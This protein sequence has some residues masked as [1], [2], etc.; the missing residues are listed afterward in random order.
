MNDE[1]SAFLASKAPRPVAVGTEPLPMHKA[2]FDYQKAATAFCIRQGRA[3]LFLDT[4]LGKA[5]AS[6]T[7]VVTPAGYVPIGKLLPGDHVIGADGKPTKVLGVFPQGERPGFRVTFSDDSSL[8][9]DIEHLWNVRTKTQRHRGD[10]WKTWTLAQ[11]MDRGLRADSGTAQDRL[12]IPMVDPVQFNETTDELP[13]DP[14]VLGC[15]IG[16]GGL[17]SYT[18]MMTSAD[19]E[20]IDRI[21]SALP[22]GTSIER[23]RYTKY[24]WVIAGTRGG[25]HHEANRVTDAL[26]DLGLM[27]HGSPEKFVP[28]PYLLG[29]EDTRRALLQGLLDTDG[30]VWLDNGCPVIEFCT[31]SKKLADD[32]VFLVQSLGGKGRAR[33]KKT[34]HLLA[35]RVTPTFPNGIAPFWLTRKATLYGERSKGMPSRSF[36]NIEPV[37]IVDMT[38]IKVEAEDGLFVAEGFIVTHNTL[39]ELEFALQGGEATNGCSL[40]LTTL[41]VAPQIEGEGWK[42]GYAPRVVRDASEV[43]AGIN[44]CNYDRLEKLD[45]SRFG[46]VALDES[47]IIKNFMGKTTGA[48]ISAFADTPFRLCATA[49]PA[50]N[51]HVELGTH[52]EFLGI[53]PRAD[54]LLR[55][56]VNDASDT[57][58]WRLK[59]HAIEP[60]WDWVSS[61]AVMAS[62]PEDMGFDGS[63]FVLPALEI[64][65][66]RT[67]GDARP[68]AGMLF[69]GDVSATTMHDIKRQTAAAR[70]D[71]VASLVHEEPHEPWMIFCDTDY[72]ADALKKRLP[73]AGDVR[74]SMSIDQKEAAIEAF[75]SGKV[76]W[77]V[78]KSR[79]MG[80][81]LNM[82]FCARMA[83]V[84]RTFSYEQWYQAV[85]RCWRFG[86]TRPVH[87][88]LIVAEGEDQI[89]R[90]LDSKA[91]AHA[92]M[93]AQMIAAS[94]R[95]I[96]ARSQIRIPYNPTYEG[97]IP[98]W[99]KSCAA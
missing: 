66:H 84:G 23:R 19:P 80:F 82:Q 31:T 90:V 95:A 91:E 55:W 39:C 26:R 97:R 28:T 45:P 89:G 17:T 49:T 48:L 53:M 20:I 40:I 43:R 83:F 56:F 12:F 92:N 16:D 78:S 94:K 24:D 1:Y 22:I 76:P 29:A 70:A 99:L 32:F 59:G 10:G 13:I 35:Y 18:P 69:A 75:L 98:S 65:R 27:G 5:L 4:G 41:A 34:T 85:R 93:K 58:T 71:A 81:G 88:H 87:V 62:S 67:I 6:D 52:A 61:W 57:G 54:M 38:C 60:F 7:M 33:E 42:Y 36:R 2:L 72:E 8:V 47:G 11:I 46:C 14:Y 74:G 25:N 96:H 86:Q 63:R 21:R 68:A 79:I 9:C 50:P 77:M 3:A 30:S 73:E 37:G 15:L 51:D 64:H 44:I